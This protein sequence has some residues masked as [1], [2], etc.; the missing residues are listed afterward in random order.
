VSADPD[1]QEILAVLNSQC[2]IVQA[3]ANGPKLSINPLEM[4]RG[5]TRIAANQL[6][7]AIRE[8]LNL[9]R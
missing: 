2:A 9:F 1:P 4:Q 8:P 6:V 3:D 7:V 5:M